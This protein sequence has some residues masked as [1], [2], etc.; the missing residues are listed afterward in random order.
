MTKLLLISDN[1]GD[2]KVIKDILKKETFDIS[3]H[4]GDS[5]LSESFMKKC[6]THYVQGN[7]DSYSPEQEIFEVEGNKII[8]G[9][10]HYFFGMFDIFNPEK[11]AARFAK[12]NDANIV[13]F[14]H[15]HKPCNKKIGNILCVNPGSCSLPRNPEGKSYAIMTIDKEKVNVEIKYF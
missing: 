1:H 13:I 2:S 8:I 6:F 15:S 7:H 4:L 12:D 14:G 5:Q 11:G 9:H 10:G 3:V